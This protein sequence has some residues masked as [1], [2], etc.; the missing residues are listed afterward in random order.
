[1]QPQEID[2][3]PWE[4]EPNKETGMLAKAK[5]IVSKVKHFWE[6]GEPPP[7]IVSTPKPVKPKG[8]SQFETV[9]A[10]LIHAESKGQHTDASG[11]LTTSG[12]GAQGITQLMAKTAQDPGYGV[13][14]V[15][16]SSEKEY[17]RFGRDYLKAMLKEFGG[18]YEKALAA[19]NAGVGNVKKA[20]SRGG[21][22][23]KEHLPK[24]EETLPYINK[25]LSP[26]VKAVTP[27]TPG[28][29]DLNNRPKVKNSD[30]SISTVRSIGVNIDGKE[31]LI[32]TVVGNRVV[33]EKEAIEH[34][35][36]TGEHLGMFKSARDSTAYAKELHKKQEDIYMRGKR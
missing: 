19:Y 7:Q 32:P 18:D 4:G 14:P 28:N 5:E 30:G 26:T 24:R 35:K 17:L 31:V 11:K 16:D 34:Y 8:D 3:N 6:D 1:M 15:K 21:V 33:S 29:I 22:S 27:I 36:Q 23:W 12:A 20:V 10:K 2:F 13:K 9:F 25:I